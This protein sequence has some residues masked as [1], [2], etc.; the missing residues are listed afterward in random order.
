MDNWTQIHENHSPFAA[1]VSPS[2]TI[3]TQAIWISN[4]PLPDDGSANVV[5][6][7]AIKH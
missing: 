3:D 2:S 4:D 1:P 7:N 5:K 6:V